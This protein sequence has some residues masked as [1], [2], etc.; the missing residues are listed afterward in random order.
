[1]F[2][3]IALAPR[4]LI[5]V[6]FAISGQRLTKNRA[7]KFIAVLVAGISGCRENTSTGK[8]Q[9]DTQLSISRFLKGNQAST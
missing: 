9:V 3:W 2:L 5:F 6:F 4:T 8:F 7:R 1:M